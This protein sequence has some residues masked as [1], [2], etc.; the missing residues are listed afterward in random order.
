VKKEPS[1]P[2]RETKEKELPSKTD[3]KKDI[4]RISKERSTK[5]RSSHK[6]SDKD[7][8]KKNT[9]I[10]PNKMKLKLNEMMKSRSGLLLYKT[11]N[12]EHPT[13]LRFL[14]QTIG[15]SLLLYY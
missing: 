11:H 10:D 8:S 15:F 3:K 1:T 13:T 14:I 7:R 9:K 2:L 12:N 6:E 5:E 4:D